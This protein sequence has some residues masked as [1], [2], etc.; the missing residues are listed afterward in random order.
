MH[1]QTQA[2]KCLKW[3][4]L[5]SKT[6]IKQT[7]SNEILQFTKRPNVVWS[8]QHLQSLTRPD[9]KEN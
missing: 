9:N 6:C 5:L 2:K 8:I 1:A 4:F 3:S 7:V